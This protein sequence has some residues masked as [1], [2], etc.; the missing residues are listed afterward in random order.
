MKRNVQNIQIVDVLPWNIQ[1]HKSCQRFSVKWCQ[2]WQFHWNTCWLL[3]HL[4]KSRT[5]LPGD[6]CCLLY[7]YKIAASNGW[8][9]SRVYWKIFSFNILFAYITKMCNWVW[10][11][12]RKKRISNPWPLTTSEMAPKI[13]QTP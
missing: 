2:D 10:V 7:A 5:S 8:M 6:S 4:A 11:T 12:K 1:N 3:A 13:A 9:C